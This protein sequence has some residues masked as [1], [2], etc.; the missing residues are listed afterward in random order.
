MAPFISVEV[1]CGLWYS[2]RILDK[3]SRT[4]WLVILL[5]DWLV[6]HCVDRFLRFG[7]GVVFSFLVSTWLVENN[8][9]WIASKEKGSPA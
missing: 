6:L 8:E 1:L 4:D 5:F 7:E 2:G 3:G 9:A